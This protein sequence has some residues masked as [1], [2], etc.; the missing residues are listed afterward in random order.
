VPLLLG[1]LILAVAVVGYLIWSRGN[2]NVAPAANTAVA[3][4]DESA[5]PWRNPRA[6][7]RYCRSERHDPIACDKVRRAHGRWR[8]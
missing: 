7:W 1:L 3:Q 5:A 2:D 4:D 6:D 8:R